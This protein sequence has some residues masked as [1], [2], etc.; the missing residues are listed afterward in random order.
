M[1][2][3]I[4]LF[5]IAFYSGLSNASWVAK[6]NINLNNLGVVWIL[7]SDCE[8]HNP[9]GCIKVPFDF[10]AEYFKASYTAKT[11][12][13]SCADADAC[14]QLLTKGCPNHGE[15]RFVASDN[16]SVYCTKLLGLIEV[17]AKKTAWETKQNEAQAKREQD[18][19][20]CRQNLK[21][22]NKLTTLELT[23][24]MKTFLVE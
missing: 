7:Q 1:M 24:C 9:D 3:P 23:Q 22:K 17:P 6:K 18:S 10:N 21:A 4:I 20:S 12:V 11:G 8:K 16:Q 13:E 5:A 14:N 19:A 2:F 15:K